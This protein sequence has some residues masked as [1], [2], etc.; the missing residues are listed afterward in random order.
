MDSKG[1]CKG[2][3]SRKACKAASFTSMIKKGTWMSTLTSA[4]ISSSSIKLVEK[5]LDG[6]KSM[7][8]S[9]ESAASLSALGKRYSSGIANKSPPSRDKAGMARQDPVNAS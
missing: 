6:P 9:C 4:P 3:Y 8:S 1:S 5:T 7:A 2:S